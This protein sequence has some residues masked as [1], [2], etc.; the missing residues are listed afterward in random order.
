MNHPQ[1]HAH[2]ATAYIF[3]ETPPNATHIFPRPNP[4]YRLLFTL[5]RI[6]IGM[7]VAVVMIMLFWL[8]AWPRAD[9]PADELVE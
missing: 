4:V 9:I 6:P 2:A 1:R 8:R 7:R 5:F 3:K